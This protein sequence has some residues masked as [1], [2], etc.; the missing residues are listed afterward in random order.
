M[1]NVTEYVENAKEEDELV[2]VLLVISTINKEDES[3]SEEENEHSENAVFHN[4]LL[5][6]SY[7][8]AEE[9]EHDGI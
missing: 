4:R 9:G 2:E 5:Q 8:Y 3:E 7:I 1:V 6:N